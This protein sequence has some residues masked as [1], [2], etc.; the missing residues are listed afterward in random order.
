MSLPTVQVNGVVWSQ[1]VVGNRAYVTGN[2]STARPAG[3]AP[4]T[5]EVSRRYLLA[6]DLE[7]AR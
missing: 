5:N 7:P 6:Y 4:G 3:A 2:F 1:L